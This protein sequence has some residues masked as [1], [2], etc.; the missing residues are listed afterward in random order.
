M[1]LLVQE[2]IIK[3]SNDPQNEKASSSVEERIASVYAN[4]ILAIDQLAYKLGGEI[5]ALDLAYWLDEKA[6]EQESKMM[7][8]KTEGQKAGEQ[9]EQQQAL[10]PYKK[11]LPPK[12]Q[13]VL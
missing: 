9:S 11:L 13:L 10:A 3:F 4:T 7:A 12:N 2:G 5:P 1:S 8:A 6:R